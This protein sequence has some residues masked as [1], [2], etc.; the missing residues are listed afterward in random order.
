MKKFEAIKA[1]RN[2]DQLLDAQYG[3][4]GTKK[5]DAFEVKA[6]HYVLS[7][8]EKDT[9]ERGAE[10]RALRKCLPLNSKMIILNGTTKSVCQRTF[11]ML[12]FV[13]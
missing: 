5:R 9:L 4:V 6:Q 7:E 2:F 11:A 3:N 12:L 10:A 13:D 8:L 1:A